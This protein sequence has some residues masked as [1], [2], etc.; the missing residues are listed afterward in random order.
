MLEPSRLVLYIINESNQNRNE[1]PTSQET[2][3]VRLM[4]SPDIIEF[5]IHFIFYIK[6]NK[7]YN[8]QFNTY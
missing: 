6:N 7:V 2:I 4:D 8:N 1:I 5:E 3:S